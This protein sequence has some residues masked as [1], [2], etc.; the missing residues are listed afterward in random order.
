M[1]P[2]ILY[3]ETI[4]LTGQITYIL[5]AIR[6]CRLNNQKLYICCDY[7]MFGDLRNYFEFPEDVHFISNIPPGFMIDQTQVD[8]AHP[9]WDYQNAPYYKES[10]GNFEK[11]FKQGYTF[12][13]IRD[14]A[15]TLKPLNITKSFDCEYDAV[16]VRRGDKVTSGDNG[17]K[18]SHTSEYLKHVTSENVFVMSDDY[19]AVLECKKYSQKNVLS[20]TPEYRRGFVSIP[21][22]QTSGSD[23]PF[24]NKPIEHRISDTKIFVNELYIAS[25]SKKFIS[26]FKSNV[27]EFI[28]L[29]HENENCVDINGLKVSDG[30]PF[31]NN[32]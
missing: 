22:Y 31:F 11:L 3:T 1:R 19:N 25:K 2:F 5:F 12:K 14:I 15:L 8:T 30:S 18:D 6:Y 7:N 24:I 28:N 9:N 29:I 10:I 26:N 13:E 21:F 32:Y 27:A 4:G 20:I 23:I 17:Y 16:L